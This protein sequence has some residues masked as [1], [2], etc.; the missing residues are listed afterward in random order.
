MKFTGKIWIIFEPGAS[1]SKGSPDDP[2]GIEGTN[3]PWWGS[4][5][6]NRVGRI[7]NAL[8]FDLKGISNT[9]GTMGFYSPAPEF[10]DKLAAHPQLGAEKIWAVYVRKHGFFGEGASPTRR[11]FTSSTNSGALSLSSVE[12]RKLCAEHLFSHVTPHWALQGLFDNTL[13]Q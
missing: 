5:S 6:G 8:R 4:S 9:C 13:I 2:R 7:N 11:I 1:C 3:I 12:A 10:L